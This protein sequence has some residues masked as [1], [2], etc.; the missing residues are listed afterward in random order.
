MYYLVSVWAK[1]GHLDQ[2]DYCLIGLSFRIMD[3]YFCCG[4]GPKWGANSFNV[5]FDLFINKTCLFV[6]CPDGGEQFQS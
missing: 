4:P 1:F 5:D 3:H 2:V 6:T